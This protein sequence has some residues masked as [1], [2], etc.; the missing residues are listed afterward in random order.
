[1]IAQ[2]P[3]A[4]TSRPHWTLR[5]E[6]RV[7][8]WLMSVLKRAGWQ[9]RVEPFVGYGAAPGVP[10]GSKPAQEFQ[11]SAQPEQDA[12]WV[13]VLARVMVS[14]KRRLTGSSSVVQEFVD[15]AP[16]HSGKR[17]AR[18]WR[19][20]FNAQAPYAT[21]TVRV[22]DA[23]YEVRA[24]P[25]G[26]IDCVLPAHFEAG[27]HEVAIST[28][29]GLIAR[30]G[31][32]VLGPT[33]TVGLV[34]DIDDTV[35]VTAV[36]RL[37]LAAWNTL[38]VRESARRAVPGMAELHAKLGAQFPGLPV[39]YLSTGA[40]NVVPAMLRFLRFHGLAQGSLLMTDFGPTNTGWFRSGRAHKVR[41]LNRLAQDFPDMKWV[42]VGD[43]GQRDP[44]IYAEFNRTHPQNVAAIA[45]RQL[46]A[47]Q[48]VLAHGTVTELK[49]AGDKKTAP[50][51]QALQ[52]RG[53]DGFEIITK[54]HS[55]GFLKGT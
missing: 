5:T 9:E 19:S 2:V 31:V 26:Y 3:L 15:P 53:R 47:A 37:L 51:D 48:S 55:L 27:W 28:S 12:G 17:A 18:G 8:T 33:D 21:V 16:G 30:V 6:T 50:R 39:M 1:M 42:L 22:G 36:P 7:T 20:Y 35:L 40:W 10:T 52:V 13:R 34:S 54:L 46:T 29:R 4:V 44:S 11:G 43:D 41:T 32:Q 38:V 45:I 25:G 49:S 23:E 14:P 24:D